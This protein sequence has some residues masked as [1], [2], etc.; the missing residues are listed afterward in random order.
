[1]D[2]ENNYLMCSGRETFAGG[3]KLGKWFN[4]INTIGTTLHRL[5]H[6]EGVEDDGRRGDIIIS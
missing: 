3:E 1:M 6:R 4:K 2:L 5:K